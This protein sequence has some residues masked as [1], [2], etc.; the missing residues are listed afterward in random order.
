MTASGWHRKAPR[1]KGPSKYDSAEH[2]AARA[3]YRKLVDYGLAVCWRCG[4]LLVP[5]AWHV[6]H[7]DV[8]TNVIR[9]PECASCNLKAGAR[10]GAKVANAKRKAARATAAFVRPVR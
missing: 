10:K 5:G 6:G 3:H 1:P 9:G 7:D 4:R 8:N 2:R